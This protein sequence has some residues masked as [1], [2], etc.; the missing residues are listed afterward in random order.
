MYSF[1]TYQDQLLD[2]I[3]DMLDDV[4]GVLELDDVGIIALRRARV[5]ISRA[6]TVASL[7][8]LSMLITGSM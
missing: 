4:H 1:E 7:Q 2:L 8:D 6:N 5:K 3:D